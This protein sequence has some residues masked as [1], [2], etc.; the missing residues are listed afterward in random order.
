M[1]FDVLSDIALAIQSIAY[2]LK[3]K[4]ID[5]R[6]ERG[7]DNESQVERKRKKGRV[8]GG[9]KDLGM[10]RQRDKKREKECVREGQIDRQIDI[11][12][13]GWKYKN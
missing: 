13:D 12:R 11:V 3:Q 1:R 8:R 7:K 4:A 5:A 9:D 10:K 2:S 6:R